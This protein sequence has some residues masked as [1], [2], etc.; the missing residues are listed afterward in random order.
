MKISLSKLSAHPLN[1]HFDRIGEKWEAMVG[2]V[3]EH[4][5]IQMPLVRKMAPGYQIVCGH[6]RAAAAEEAGLESIECEVRVMDDRTVLE[7]LVIENLE[8]E[9]PDPVE[10]GKLLRALDAEGVDIHIL[11]H[12]LKRSVEWITT[13]QRLLDLGEE[14]LEAVRLPRESPGHLD[15]GTVRVIL[16]V[17][18][19]ERERAIQL[20]LHPEWTTEV[21]GQREAESVIKSVILEPARKKAAWEKESPGWVKAWKKA[22]GTFLTKEQKKE[23]IVQALRWHDVET[24][25]MRT[26]AEDLIPAERLAAAVK[27][28]EQ[29]RWVHLAILH[30]VPVWVIP[31]SGTAEAEL[32]LAVV[33]ERLLV[34]AEEAAAEP[35]YEMRAGEKVLVRAH[36][37]TPV[38]LTDKEARAKTARE[39]RLQ[40]QDEK[41]QQRIEHAEAELEGGGDPSYPDEEKP[42]QVITQ[43]MESSAWVDLGPVRE[44]RANYEA[45]GE[46]KPEWAQMMD[47]A[48][49]TH[50]IPDVCLWFEG[51]KK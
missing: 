50:L 2:S 7:L 3:R 39:K 48:R 43:H 12:R 42:E 27:A 34:M 35:L 24:C 13:R 23:L 22:L 37:G 15:I 51:L 16:S 38:L 49:M 36:A 11:A 47:T 20:V 4:G 26:K 17:P 25:K 41:R 40:E 31:G 44:L 33:D 46:W 28:E 45:A 1:R 14:V 29:K 32:S 30:G 10:E 6:R 18:D 21:L 5:V 9:N 19:S 8:R